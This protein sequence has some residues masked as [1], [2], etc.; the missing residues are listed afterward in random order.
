MNYENCIDKLTVYFSSS[1]YQR[2]VVKAKE[3]F[4][5]DIGINER[6]TGDFER[7]LNLFFDWYLFTRS[8]QGTLLTPAK[9]ALDLEG[10]QMTDEERP[11]FE[12]LAE[13]RYGLFE[14]IKTKGNDHY[15]KN[16]LTG[17]KIVVKNSKLTMFTP[18]GSIFSTHFVKDQNT[19][20]F[21]TGMI[22]HP[23]ETKK[24]ILQEIKKIQKGNYED[25]WK[26]I[27][28]LIKMYFK[29][30]RYPHVDHQQIYS[31]NSAV[32]F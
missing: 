29:L 11:Y 19:N 26:M 10:F 32:R 1:K 13:A 6:D 20:Y 24:F 14:Y 23:L 4:F 18:K 9:M 31:L 3:Q 8:L 22:C 30:E 12:G 17:E 25:Q 21:T 7:N 15:A 16:L 2:E 27:I 5:G 28:H